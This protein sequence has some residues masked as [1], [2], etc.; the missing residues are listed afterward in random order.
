[1]IKWHLRWLDIL[2]VGLLGVTI[3]SAGPA[4][5]WPVAIAG[6]AITVAG[7]GLVRPH[8]SL[9]VDRAMRWTDLAGTVLL[10]IGVAVA[11]YADSV[12]SALT[13]VVCPTVWIAVRVFRRGGVI[14]TIVLVALTV[15]AV[16]VRSATLHTLAHDWPMIAVSG[17]LVLVFSLAMGTMVH[18]VKRWGAERQEL[19]EES[20][21]AQA[22]L[23]ES[24]RQ[25]MASLPPAPELASECPLSA[26]ELE[27]LGLV[28]DGCTNR[29]IGRRLFI[30][31]ATVKTHMEHIL[32]KLGATTRTQAVLTA[33]HEGYVRPAE[34]DL[35]A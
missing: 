8:L 7:Y 18:S 11:S 24:Y 29:E 25:L 13:A 28:S 35:P 4:V 5:P 34:A 19:L 32:T 2:L 31:T 6:L 27:V 33:Y 26:R 30:S 1:V 10:M 15:L 20:Q 17:L 23:A 16:G 21:A 3:A 22:D 14:A 12:F 9:T